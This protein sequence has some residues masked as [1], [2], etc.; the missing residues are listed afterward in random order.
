MG[1]T[2]SD[3]RHERES[4]AAESHQEMRKCGGS[5]HRT[6]SREE[7]RDRVSCDPQE[8][9]KKKN[10]KMGHRAVRPVALFLLCVWEREGQ[11]WF[12]KR[13]ETEHSEIC[14]GT[15]VS[16][17]HARDKVGDTSGM[18]QGDGGG[19]GHDGIAQPGYVNDVS[20]AR[21]QK[22]ACYDT[23]ARKDDNTTAWNTFPYRTYSDTMLASICAC[24]SDAFSDGMTMARSHPQLRLCATSLLCTRL[25][26][27]TSS[28]TMPGHTK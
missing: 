19:N 22:L 5:A 7:E 10:R 15:D 28:T 17:V 25:C 13:E 2:G 26:E 12:V 18:Q 9:K 24:S 16:V 27:R 8:R 1:E 6:Q 21:K 3:A 4:E 20:H 23:H 14:R 11:R